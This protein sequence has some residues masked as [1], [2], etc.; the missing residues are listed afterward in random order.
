MNPTTGCD[1]VSPGCDRRRRSCRLPLLGPVVLEDRW[2]AGGEGQ[3]RIDWLIA[4][5]ESGRG[6]RPMHP[7]WARS[8]R[9]QCIRHQVAYLFKQWGEWRPLEECGAGRP[10]RA[11]S[12]AGRQ[13]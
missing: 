9:D 4:G 2:L 10:A 1:R 3:A 5:G 11:E 12:C 6:A 7:Q 13:R 8:L